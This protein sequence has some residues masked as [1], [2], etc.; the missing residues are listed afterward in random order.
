MGREL[1]GNVSPQDEEELLF[2]FLLQYYSPDHNPPEIIYLSNRVNAALLKEFFRSQGWTETSVE[3]PQEGRHRS[4]VR[5]AWEN[6]SMDVQK[7][8]KASAN[9]PALEELRIAAGAWKPAQT[10]RGF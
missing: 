7:R 9:L 4:V 1:Y 5:M 3:V 10:Y 8:Q 6:A 2:D